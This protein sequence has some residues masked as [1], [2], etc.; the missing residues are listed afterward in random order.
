MRMVS[1]SL[2]SRA[3]TIATLLAS[4]WLA[5]GATAFSF[6][7]IASP[8]LDLTDLGRVALAGD[9][10]S[11][12]LYQFEGQNENAASP[13]AGSLLTRFPN[14]VFTSLQE[15][16]GEIRAMCPFI[17]NGTLQG[18]VFG[19][20]FTS[21]GGVAAQGIALLNVDNAN[22]TALPG[23]N[24]SVNA[25]FCDKDA[26]R[27]YVGGSFTG[28]GAQN[29]IV[30]ITDWTN[31]PFSG[32]NGPVTTIAKASNGNIIFGGT[33]DGLGNTTTPKEKD[34]QVIP[35]GS[36]NITAVATTTTAGFSDPRNII[37]KTGSQ[38]GPGNTWLLE[39][40]APG[41]WQANFGFGFQPSKLRLYNTVQSDRGTKEWRFTALPDGGIMNFTYINS[42]GETAYC[43]SRCPLPQNNNTFQDFHFVNTVGMN[44]FRIDIS[45]WYGQGAGLSGIELFENDIYSFAVNDFN[46]PLCDGVSTTGASSSST[47]PWS[48]SPSGQ[49]NAQ[50][51]TANLQGSN[52]TADSAEVVFKPDIK[53]SGNYTVTIFTPGCTIDN[54][55]GTRG[56]VNVTGTMAASA[57]TGVQPFQ[58]VE[59]F[60]TNMFDKYDQ[61]Y[62]GY[63]DAN[64][65]AF[66]PTITLTPV[67]GQT[68]P[69]TV[70]AQRVRFELNSPTTGGL[71][72]LFEYDTNK[73]VVSSDFS[74]SAI[75]VAGAGLSPSQAPVTSILV[76]GD[77]LYVGG[78]FTGDGFSNIFS[79]SGGNATS[80]PGKGLDSEVMT[81]YQNGSTLYVGGNFTNTE[82]GKSTGLK[83][84]AAYSTTNK[85]WSPLGAG[86][87]GV[88]MYM[89]PVPLNFTEENTTEECLYISGTFDSVFGSG[90]D[91]TFSTDNSAIWVPSRQNWLHNLN[92]T[93]ISVSGV[94][95][96]QSEIPGSAPIFSGSVSSQAFGASGAVQLTSG[97]TLG[98]EQYPISVQ[99]QTSSV[100][101]RKRAINGQETISGVVTGLIYTENNLNITLLAGHFAATGSD[102]ANITNL[103]FVNGSNS[104][105]VTGMGDGINSD[106]VFLSVAAYGTTLF[107]GGV[108]SGKVNT[109]NVG[110][111]VLYDLSTASY[112]SIQ[113]AGLQGSDGAVTAIAP[114][115]DSKDVYVGGNFL[116]AGALSCPSVC[117]WNTERSQWV[118]PGNGLSGNVSS[119]TWI[120]NNN[121][122]IAGNLT[123]NGNTT[124]LVTF[125]AQKHEF[126]EFTGASTVPGPVTAFCPANN[127][128]SQ[129]WVAGT[130]SNDTAFL[131]KFDGEK[132]VPAAT[133]LGAGTDIRGI[134]VLSLSKDHDKTDLLENNQVLLVLGQVNVTGFGNAS[135]VLFNGT[136]FT[137]FILSNT[138]TNSPGSL[139]QA[140]VENPQN[141]FHSKKKHLALG[142]VV[143]IGLAIALAITF[144]VVVLGI[145][146]ER[147]RKKQQG[148]VPANQQM[149]DK[150]S[151]LNRVPPEHLFGTLHGN[152]NGRGPL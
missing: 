130:A 74:T 149:F 145:L 91:K 60:Q 77:T 141:F 76:D 25:L 11:I 139:S 117:I 82:D 17:S 51:L 70:V 7:P 61:I 94:L 63:V 30:W 44:S 98:L 99:P 126:T 104:D 69:L 120:S 15:T 48:V 10:D 6:A 125:N 108:I 81:M 131:E 68:G 147:L 90:K 122:L 52:I 49:S 5:R 59:L 102:G 85:A 57:R 92:L 36:A 129:F 24:G 58:S 111:L 64:D 109:N 65:D 128:G 41:F 19:G 135:A 22:I 146:A 66:R 144:L 75:D 136:A 62:Y 105:I 118:S 78:N 87:N 9:F 67:A 29:A 133:G 14:G 121:L 27:V 42:A 8:D 45:A 152:G 54:T 138:G 103:L 140:F 95:M 21:V 1:S 96:A 31:M 119:M 34:V 50:Y 56:K 86:V 53:Q 132:W 83:G 16:D 127:D 2:A 84:V 151:N 79:V 37:C 3:G 43:D 71:N 106:S 115:P 101:L 13:S 33:F 116:S 148:Y 93:T 112:A 107:A 38:D 32:F 80:L 39:D 46:E 134:Q 100:S 89:V 47:G 20:N 72:G 110:G 4:L 97:K 18:I 28:G 23:L 113:P 26:S 123:V 35:V 150:S 114:Q 143:L 124:T 12:S 40:N 137:P 73:Q 55:C 88:V 142:F